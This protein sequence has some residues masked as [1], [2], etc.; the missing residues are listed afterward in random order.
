MKKAEIL[1]H[2][3]GIKEGEESP[4]YAVLKKITYCIGTLA[5]C[6]DWMEALND[7]PTYLSHGQAGKSHRIALI[8]DDDADYQSWLD[9]VDWADCP[10]DDDDYD[11]NTIWAEDRAYEF[12]GILPVQGNDG[13]LLLVDLAVID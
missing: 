13:R 12:D 5:E 6:Q 4:T 7:T 10:G 9:G 3:Q 8:L 2:W 11:G 1:E